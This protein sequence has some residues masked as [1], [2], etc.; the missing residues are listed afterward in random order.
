MNMLEK[1]REKERRLEEFIEQYESK[2]E[3]MSEQIDLDTEALL[4]RIRTHWTAS[5]IETAKKHAFA[6]QLGLEYMPLK[7]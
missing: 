6:E 2:V 4:V 5:E 3:K 1:V 7:G